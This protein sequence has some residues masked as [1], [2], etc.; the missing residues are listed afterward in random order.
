MEIIRWP[1]TAQ[2]WPTVP[3]QIWVQRRTEFLY[4]ACSSRIIRTRTLAKTG[5][6]GMDRRRPGKWGLDCPKLRMA[7][8]HQYDCDYRLIKPLPERRGHPITTRKIPI[9]TQIPPPPMKNKGPCKNPDAW[10]QETLWNPLKARRMLPVTTRRK[11]T[12]ACMSMRRTHGPNY[13]NHE[14]ISREYDAWTGVRVCQIPTW[15]I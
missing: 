8:C 14:C 6:L 10:W 4:I 2:T 15:K 12:S 9:W 7:V 3:Y 11:T 5:W 1:W 13:R